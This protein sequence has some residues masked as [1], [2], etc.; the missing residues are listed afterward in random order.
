MNI[1]ATYKREARKDLVIGA[2]LL[3][4]AF[5]LS[6]GGMAAFSYVRGA[7]AAPHATTAPT[8]PTCVGTNITVW[9]DDPTPC[10]VVPGQSLDVA[11]LTFANDEPWLVCD[12]MGGDWVGDGVDLCMGVDF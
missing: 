10:D 5:I 6:F 12:D 4:S 7:Q 9:K 2:V 8:K 11:G 3:L 1:E